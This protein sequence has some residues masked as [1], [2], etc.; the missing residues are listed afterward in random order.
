MLYNT[1]SGSIR[2]KI[3]G[4]EG[5]IYSVSFSP[6]GK[7]FA[8]GGA[9]KCVII[10]NSNTGRGISKYTHSTSTQVVSFCPDDSSPDGLVLFSGSCSDFGFW[11]S[12]HKG[13]SKLHLESKVLCCS[14]TKDGQS[15]AI[16]MHSG[17]VSLRNRSGCELAKMVRSAPIWTLCWII[18]PAESGDEYLVVGCWDKSLSFYQRS[19]TSSN[20][21]DLEIGFYPLHIIQYGTKSLLISGSNGK[22]AAYSLSSHLL[23]NLPLPNKDWNW[24]ISFDSRN[25]VYIGDNIGRLISSKVVYK[26]VYTK[27]RDIFAIRG[28]NQ[29]DLHIH[30]VPDGRRVVLPLKYMITGLS[31]C[32]DVVA[33][34]HFFNH[35]V[36]LYNIIN[37]ADQ[38][39][40]TFSRRITYSKTINATEMTAFL[41]ST[42]YLYICGRG[43]LYRS[44]YNCDGTRIDIESLKINI[45]DATDDNILLVL[46]D[47]SIQSYSFSAKCSWEKLKIAQMDSNITSIESNRSQSMILVLCDD[48]SLHLYNSGWTQKVLRKETVKSFAFNEIN[49]NMFCLYS[50]SKIRIYLVD[51]ELCCFL[52]ESIH[53][54]SIAKFFGSA[55][56]YINSVDWTFQIFHLSTSCA[57]ENCISHND[58]GTAF[59]VA[60]SM[61]TSEKG[62][63]FLGNKAMRAFEFKIAKK[64]LG[65]AGDL[66]F[67][68]YLDVWQSQLEMCSNNIQSQ[69]RLRSLLQ[70]EICAMQGNYEKAAD[71]YLEAGKGEK[72]VELYVDLKKWE[73][74]KHYARNCEH[75]SYKDIVKSEAKWLKETSNDWKEASRLYIEC[76]LP[77]HAAQVLSE[78]LEHLSDTD[79]L[80]HH[81]VQ[82]A[83]DLPKSETKALRILAQTLMRMN[84]TH[85]VK[86][87]YQ[88]LDDG[89]ELMRLSISSC[90]WA[91][92][93]RYMNDYGNLFD[94]KLLTYYC[95]SLIMDDMFEEAI[96][97]YR[98]MGMNVQNKALILQL[99]E[100]AIT[101]CRYRDASYFFWTMC[102]ELQQTHAV[103]L[104]S[105]YC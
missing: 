102:I 70:G 90:D 57:V 21:D 59:Q 63:N 100:N 8:S 53:V 62:W 82:I 11:S 36:D 61:E 79:S 10:W 84:Q 41:I 35:F 81:I 52:T 24:S 13:V 34:G 44:D 46:D 71:F 47:H 85:H 4:H 49:E 103:R 87:I 68:G 95:E 88:K 72:A 19:G 12:Q 16:G 78:A 60:C 42:Q 93:A 91:N 97:L 20:L 77:N 105:S 14:W 75:N 40:C 92:A 30:S 28:S 33:V 80:C 18:S 104:S 17:L 58:F 101:E 54:H 64:A 83:N 73:K 25:H 38:L 3:D 22:V 43:F 76:G 6:D 31:S 15:I 65:R 96:L 9:D 29:F 94:A 23:H 48:E 98:K 39:S 5:S 51:K 37:N 50:E 32:S 2:Q 99:A 89:P 86:S 7:R 74:A 56:C 27:G 66:R 1:K 26:L 69:Q 45:F 67:H 55:F